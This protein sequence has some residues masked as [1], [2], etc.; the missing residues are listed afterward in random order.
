M[1][2]GFLKK[3][4]KSLNKKWLKAQEVL[5]ELS[6]NSEFVIASDSSH[7]VMYGRA[8]IIKKAVLEM[9]NGGK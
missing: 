1:E 8:D 9:A 3:H 7:A 2:L 4:E 5:T 6:T